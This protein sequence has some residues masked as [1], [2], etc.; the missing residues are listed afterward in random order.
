MRRQLFCATALFVVFI[1]AHANEVP[2]VAIPKQGACPS[3]YSTSGAF[4]APS[5][6]AK[7]AVVKVG[8]CPSGYSTSSDY[9]LSSK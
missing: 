5:S 6:S 4:C 1:L 7:F 9:C 8:N 2:A 3:G